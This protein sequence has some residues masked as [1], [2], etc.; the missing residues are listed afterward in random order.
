M[1]YLSI[2]FKLVFLAL[3]SLALSGCFMDDEALITQET[4]NVESGGEVDIYAREG[5]RKYRWKQIS[6]TPVAI[7]N[8]RSSTLKFTAPTVTE[9]I[10]L[11][12]KLNA[13]FDDPI[14]DQITISVYPILIINGYRLPPEPNEEE[15]N[16][17]L[18]GIDS[19][20]NGVRDDVE[21]W[22][23]TTFED[24]HPVHIE[25]GMQSA[26]TW[27]RIFEDPSNPETT[28]MVDAAIDCATYYKI[29]SDPLLIFEHI[30]IFHKVRWQTTNNKEREEAFV[31]YDKALSG[32][33]YTLTK[34]N[35]LK[36]QCTFDIDNI[37][38]AQ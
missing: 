31:A 38:G 7:A 22:I 15:N 27:K 6:G 14:H 33:V 17:T 21:R 32:G 1:K 30:S 23:Y 2:G 35:K 3:F 26:R 29:Y 11:V 13:K 24:K 28:K 10:D 16:A 5:G 9:K 12:F 18:E 36:E 4:L 8:K 20:D 25:V 19:N 34:V 37:V